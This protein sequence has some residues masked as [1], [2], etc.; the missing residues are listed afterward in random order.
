MDCDNCTL[1]KQKFG[2]NI[3]SNNP[4]NDCSGDMPEGCL[5]TKVLAEA[6]HNVDLLSDI[7]PQDDSRYAEA[8]HN[9]A[10]SSAIDTYDIDSDTYKIAHEHDEWMSEP[11]DILEIKGPTEAPF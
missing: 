5:I 1:F 9:A 8:L 3:R 7:I 10:I 2:R 6:E 4:V 11:I